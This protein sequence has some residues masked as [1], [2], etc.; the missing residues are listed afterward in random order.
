[1]RF[2]IRLILFFLLVSLWS[3]QKDEETTGI[4]DV[5]NA[6]FPIQIG[7]WISYQIQEI[8]ID[9]ESAVNDT[10]SYQIKEKIES[11]VEKTEQYKTYRLERYFRH[12]ETEDWDILNVWQLRQYTTRIH[13]IEEN[14]EYIRLVTP[15]KINRN[16]DGNTYNNLEAQV[17]QISYMTDSIVKNQNQKIAV[18]TQDNRES[19]IDKHLSQEQYVTAIGLVKKVNIDVELNIDPNLP[20]EQKI[21][22]G[23][24]YYQ[25]FIDTNE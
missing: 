13:K 12:N 21:T 23:T 14:I 20:W 11:L 22:K 1:M 18:V 10:V 16:W 5:E 19:L 25:D 7:H 8:N 3:C 24:I 4:A 15:V 2:Y 17:Y 6:Y 9:Q